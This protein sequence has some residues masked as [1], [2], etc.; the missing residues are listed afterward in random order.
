MIFDEA[1]QARADR[2]PDFIIRKTERY[3]VAEALAG[4]QHGDPRWSLDWSCSHL[5]LM[6]ATPHM[7]KD[8]PYYALWRLLEPDVLATVDAF[9]A[10]PADA[11]RRHFLRRTKEEMVN[12]RAAAS[13]PAA[14]ATP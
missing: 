13:T 12:S 1:A 10:Y 4:I 11:R 9:N 14:S 5:L 6:T 2:Q 7:G 8:F 3:R